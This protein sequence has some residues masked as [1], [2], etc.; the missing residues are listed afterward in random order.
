MLFRSAEY[1][2]VL[3]PFS[4]D[5]EEMVTDS[6]VRYARQYPLC[7]LVAGLQLDCIKLIQ[8]QCHRDKSIV[9]RTLA[10]T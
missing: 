2:L 3:L 5:K 6:K 10:I 8:I 4:M 7:D 1:Q 9:K